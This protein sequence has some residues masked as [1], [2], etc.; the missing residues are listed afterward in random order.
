[1]RSPWQPVTI[2]A[3]SPS[4]PDGIDF[5]TTPRDRDMVAIYR[6]SIIRQLRRKNRDADARAAAGLLAGL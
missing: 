1:M 6:T 2:P 5:V 3:R 4:V